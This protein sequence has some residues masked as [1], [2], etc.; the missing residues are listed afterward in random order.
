M[1]TE[2]GKN[3]TWETKTTKSELQ[4]R[5]DESITKKH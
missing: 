5:N 2:T 3:G 4:S 1:K